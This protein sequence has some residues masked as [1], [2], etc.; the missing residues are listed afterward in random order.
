MQGRVWHVLRSDGGGHLS[1]DWMGA[2]WTYWA[3][4]LHGN[5]SQIELVF[6][7]TCIIEDS[8][9]PITKSTP[10]FNDSDIRVPVVTTEKKMRYRDGTRLLEVP[11]QGLGPHST[12]RTDPNLTEGPAL[13]SPH[14]SCS[15]TDPLDHIPISQFIQTLY[16]TH[17]TP[18]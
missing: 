8:Q 1:P 9:P 3:L 4:A 2:V 14:S 12:S 16:E 17:M 15:V 7:M 6:K 10:I 11:G 18:R 5:H 13:G